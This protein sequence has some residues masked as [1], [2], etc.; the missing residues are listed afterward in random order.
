LARALTRRSRSKRSVYH[1]SLSLRRS[2]DVGFY[3]Q[4]S[5]LPI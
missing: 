5:R 3:E 4:D 2:I 1:K